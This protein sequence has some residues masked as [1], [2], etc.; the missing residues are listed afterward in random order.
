HSLGGN[1]LYSDPD[2]AGFGGISN[3]LNPVRTENLPYRDGIEVPNS[4]IHSEV[5]LG[6]RVGAIRVG[7][8]I[9]AYRHD[10]RIIR[11]A[12]IADLPVPYR[13]PRFRFAAGTAGGKKQ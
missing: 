11:R 1:A 4:G 7:R 12:G 8:R 10:R 2:D 9:D 13:I 5:F 3:E 6:I